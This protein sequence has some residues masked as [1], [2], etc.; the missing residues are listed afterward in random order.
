MGKYARL[1]GTNRLTVRQVKL[2]I[3]CKNVNAGKGEY[4]YL[5][6]RAVF[7]NAMRK[8]ANSIPENSAAKY[9][10]LSG[11]NKMTTAQVK[12]MI[13]FVNSMI[14]KYRA[15]DNQKVRVLNNALTVL[16]RA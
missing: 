13:D 2:I 7:D 6:V 8:L 1:S 14:L 11:W 16:K 5:N 10:F 9:A 15:S 3:N 4:S 12:V